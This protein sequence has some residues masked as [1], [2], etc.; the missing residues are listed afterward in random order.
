MRDEGLLFIEALEE[1]IRAWEEVAKSCEENVL[2]VELGGA[3][4]HSAR[5]QAEKY[6]VRI[7]EVRELIQFLRNGR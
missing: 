4:R 3:A 1:H 2:P 7:A 5:E 6:R